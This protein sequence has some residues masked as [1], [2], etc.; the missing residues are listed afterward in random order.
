[1]YTAILGGKIQFETLHG[2]VVV[3]VP[4]FSKDGAK[5]R[6]KGKGMPNYNNPAQFGDLYVRIKHKMPVSLTNEEISLLKKLKDLNS[7]KGKTA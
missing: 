4:R 6:V 1:M 5:L 3:M 7:K 2:K